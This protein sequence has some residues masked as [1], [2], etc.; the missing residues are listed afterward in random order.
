MISDNVDFTKWEPIVPLA[1]RR[2][3]AIIGEDVLDAICAL[4]KDAKEPELV[5]AA[6]KSVAFFA[7]IMMIPTLDAQHGSTGR[8]KKYGDNERGL[9]ALQEFKDEQ[10]ILNIAYEATGALIDTLEHGR[11]DFWEQSE[12]KRRAHSLLIRD[13]QEFDR[14]YTIGSH[15]LYYTLSPLI[16]EAQDMDIAPIVGNEYMG[17]MLSGDPELSSLSELCRR[18]LALLT[19]KKAV[20]RLPIEVI[21]EGIVQAQQVGSVK[22]KLRARRRH[23]DRWPNRFHGMPPATCWT[24]RTPSPAWTTTRPTMTCTSRSLRCNP[25]GSHSKHT[26][27]ENSHI[28]GAHLPSPREHR[29]AGT[30]A[31]P[32]LSGNLP[33]E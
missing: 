4:Y 19:I 23:A 15:R 32:P 27:D 12:A 5:E 21:P 31:I 8:Q 6:Q 24:Y 1:T 18:P 22:E 28:Q 2:L 10:N 26:N 33:H 14:F 13:K 29:R 20:E 25:K 16:R 17:R 30:G 7:W 9:T 3:K 11:F